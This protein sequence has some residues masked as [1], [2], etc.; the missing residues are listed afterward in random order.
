VEPTKQ[1]TLTAMDYLQIQQLVSSY[2]HALDSGYGKGENGTAY[3]DLYTSDATFGNNV[4]RERLI[5]VAKI[6]PRGPDYVR[7]YLFNHVIE[8][9]PEGVKGKEYLIVIDVGENGKPST[10]YLGGHYEEIYEKT[11]D[12][13]RMKTRRLFP[14]R[15]GPQPAGAP[16]ADS[17]RAVPHHAEAAEAAAK[18]A[19]RASLTDADYMGI[20]QLA[21]RAAYALDGAADRGQAFAKLFTPDGVFRAKRPQPY[22][23]KGREQL[24]AY[25]MGDLTHRG[26][27]YVRDYTTNHI[28]FPSSEGATGRMYLIWIEVGENGNPGVVQSGGRYEDVYVRTADGWR[29]KSRTFVPSKLGPRETWEY[30]P[31][32]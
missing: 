12:G 15:S 28:I 18:D 11:A 24:A 7:H 1:S 20:Q 5:E 14:P 30:S 25:A 3:A 19:R 8:P 13:W 31:A 32:Q 2:G 16:S 17:G 29:I 23:I 22:E 10:L 9:T 4:G 27:A 6:E 21:A 26:P